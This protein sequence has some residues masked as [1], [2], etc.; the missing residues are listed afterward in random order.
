MVLLAA[1]SPVVESRSPVEEGSLV[2][3]IAAAGRSIHLEEDHNFVAD[4]P[5]DIQVVET[6][7]HLAGSHRLDMGRVDCREKYGRVLGMKCQHCCIGEEHQWAH[8][9]FVA[10]L[11]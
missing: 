8:R 5:A 1:G 10:T 7:L 3:G 2:V 4:S 6:G 9:T 11:R